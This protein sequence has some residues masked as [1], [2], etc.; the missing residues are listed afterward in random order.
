MAEMDEDIIQLIDQ[1]DPLGL[2]ESHNEKVS[3][4]LTQ[5]Q[6]FPV[7]STVTSI[8]SVTN[9]TANIHTYC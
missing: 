5:S 2:N 6:S 7:D 9:V 3:F 1:D 8:K 4:E